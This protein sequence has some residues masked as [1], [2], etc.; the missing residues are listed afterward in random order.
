MHQ[1]KKGSQEL[2]ILQKLYPFGICI[3]LFN[4]VIYRPI[5]A[6]NQKRFPMGNLF[7]FSAW[8]GLYITLL[9][10]K[11]QIPNEY[12]FCNICNSCNDNT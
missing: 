2:Q 7:W 10:R 4:N 1:T 3:F 6:P 11:I 5:H 12:N 9:N 8:I